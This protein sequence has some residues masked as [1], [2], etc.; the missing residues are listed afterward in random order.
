[1]RFRYNIQMTCHKNGILVATDTGIHSHV[2]QVTFDCLGWKRAGSRLCSGFGCGSGR[3]WE[4]ETV[5]AVPCNAGIKYTECKNGHQDQ[6]YSA[7]DPDIVE[8]T[9]NYAVLSGVWDTF[10]G[11]DAIRRLRESIRQKKKKRCC[12]HLKKS[13]KNYENML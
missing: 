4:A 6:R 3:K 2:N 9:K 7:S 5:H 13:W 10:N 11:G 1:M 8:M 12:S